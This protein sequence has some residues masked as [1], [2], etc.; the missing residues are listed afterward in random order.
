MHR[1]NDCAT[2]SWCGAPSMSIRLQF[3]ESWA[4]YAIAIVVVMPMMCGAV[5]CD[6]RASQ[7]VVCL[8][9]SDAADYEL[10]DALTRKL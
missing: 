1:V 5:C 6:P 2:Y 8:L 7:G 10:A 3:C 4:F 9:P